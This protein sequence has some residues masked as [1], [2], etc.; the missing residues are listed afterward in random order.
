M[1]QRTDIAHR[2]DV[3]LAAR[4]EGDSPIEVDGETA[5]HLIEDLA[6]DLLALLEILLEAGPAF[7]AARLFARQHGFAE[8][9][10]DPLEIDFDLV[11]DSDLGRL[12]GEPEFLKRH[13]ALGLQ[14]NIDNCQILLDGDDLALDHASFDQIVGL[15]SLVE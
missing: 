12:A 8:R 2:A 11:A 10:F 9:V 6:G 4:Q 1:H 13:A 15:E 3:D 5:L 7:F 14:S